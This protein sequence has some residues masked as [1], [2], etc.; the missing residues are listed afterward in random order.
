MTYAALIDDMVSTGAEVL[1]EQSVEIARDV[2][3]IHVNG[4]GTVEEV[5]VDGRAAVD[6]LYRAYVDALGPAVEGPL[7]SVAAEYESALALP[8]SLE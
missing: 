3:G 5:S 1:G 4:D 8:S 7:R 2:R 6:D